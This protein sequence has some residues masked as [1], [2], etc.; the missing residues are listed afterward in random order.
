MEL[1]PRNAS[2]LTPKSEVS[3][4]KRASSLKISEI[5][6]DGKVKKAELIDEDE[7]SYEIFM[8]SLILSNYA[9]V[10]KVSN[11]EANI[12]GDDIEK[13]V[14]SYTSSKGFNKSLIDSIAPKVADISLSEDDSLKASAHA[15]NEKV[16]IVSKGRPDEILARCSYILRDSRFVKVTRRICREV[17][18]ML[19]GMLSRCQE[20]YALAIK[21]IS[22][23][24][25]MLAP[26]AYVKDMALV[27]LIGMGYA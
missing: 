9:E 5:Y 13:A 18:Y 22:E 27:A 24:S 14:F 11:G 6:L 4:E 10:I 25:E 26:D 7:K 17:N 2:D 19:L 1:I 12:I 23:L 8:H 21:D 20:V 3:G 16:R 15:I